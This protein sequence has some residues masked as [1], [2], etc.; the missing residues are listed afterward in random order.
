VSLSAV[1]AAAQRAGGAAGAFSCYDLVT[2]DA[3]LLAAGRRSAA[4]VLLIPPAALAE[5]TGP[6][7]VSGCRALADAAPTPVCVQLDHVRR[8]DAVRAGLAAGANAVM[9][10]AAHRPLND[11]IAFVAEAVQIAACY[12]ADVEVEAELGRVGGDDERAGDR[13][14]GTLTDPARVDAFVRETGAM[15]LAVSIGNVHGATGGST[16]LD[17][18]RLRAIRAATAVALALHGGSGV[19]AADLRRA[20]ADGIGK[21]NVNT[22]L[23]A[24][25]LAASAAAAEAASVLEAQAAVRAGL[26]AAVEEALGPLRR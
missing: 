10:D 1:V 4:C 26:V 22:Q 6:A 20:T 16:P 8:L 7:L 13:H 14:A 23:R 15:C 11:N 3:V 19:T 18:P 24:A 5:R 2:A 25:W 21:V 9:A 17:W 12:G